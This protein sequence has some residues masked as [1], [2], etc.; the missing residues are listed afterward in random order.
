MNVGGVPRARA[1]TAPERVDALPDVSVVLPT[2]D[3]LPLLKQAIGSVEAQ[4][5]ASWEL[6]VVD[7]GSTD[8][9][10][11]Y[12]RG[13][14][15]PRI[16]LV[17]LPHGGNVARARNAGLRAAR[18][19]YVAFLDSDDLWLPGKLAVQLKEMTNAHVRWSYTGYDLID[20]KGCDVRRR[21]GSWQPRAGHIAARILTTEVGV[22]VSTLMVERGLLESVGPFDEDPALNLREDYELVLRLAVAAEAGVVPETLVR[23]REHEGR[24]THGRDDAFERTARV[25]AAFMRT[26][27]DP[28]LRRIAERRRAY[29]LAEA[30][31]E[32]LRRGAWA[33]AARFYLAALRSGVGLGQWLSAARR[34]VTGAFSRRGVP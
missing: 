16:E 10:A 26:C 13:L 19:R 27:P 29:H 3:R 1:T 7:D 9:T 8:G 20:L 33:S 17:V 24:A 34:G 6:L 32:Q 4:H 30:G 18:G 14:G 21:A 28:R 2:Y 12:V 15:D 5:F 11:E 25:Y 22:A 23:I 31:A